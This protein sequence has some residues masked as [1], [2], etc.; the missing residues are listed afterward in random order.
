MWPTRLHIIIINID[1]SGGISAIQDFLKANGTARNEKLTFIQLFEHRLDLP[2][3]K[4]VFKSYCSY[5]IAMFLK[6]SLQNSPH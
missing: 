2:K 1:I 3:S 5:I 4:Y 6:F